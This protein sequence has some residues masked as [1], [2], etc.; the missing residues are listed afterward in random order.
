M[1]PEG[2]DRMIAVAKGARQQ[3]YALRDSESLTPSCATSPGF[4]EYF[5]LMTV[6]TIPFSE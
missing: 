6:T 2:S 4:L 5:G 1:R 3:F